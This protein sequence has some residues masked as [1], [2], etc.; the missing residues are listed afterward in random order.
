MCPRNFIGPDRFAL[1]G[2]KHTHNMPDKLKEWLDQNPGTYTRNIVYRSVL[3]A[4]A[5]PQVAG[6]APP[7][8]SYLSPEAG[9]DHDDM[10]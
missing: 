6:P 7:L 5:G 1:L 4:A 3:R 9:P 2:S 8:P 10:T